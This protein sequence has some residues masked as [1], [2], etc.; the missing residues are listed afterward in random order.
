MTVNLSEVVDWFQPTY[1]S[2]V[3]R[4][5]DGGFIGLMDEEC[6]E[7]LTVAPERDLT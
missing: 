3:I 1:N 2:V 6:W 7:F 4:F 5:S